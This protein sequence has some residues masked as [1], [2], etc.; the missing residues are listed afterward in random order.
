[1]LS[2][3]LGALPLLHPL[4]RDRRRALADCLFVFG[5]VLARSPA[6]RR[7]E[8]RAQPAAGRTRA[9]RARPGGADRMA[10]GDRRRRLRRADRGP[11]AIR[12][13]CGGSSCRCRRRVSPPRSWA[14]RRSTGRWPVRSSTCCCLPVRRRSRPCSAPSSRRSC[15]AWPAT[16]RAASAI[17]EGLMVLLLKPYLSSAELLPTLV[18]YRAVYYLLAAVGGPRGSGRRRNQAAPLTNR[19]GDGAARPVVGGADAA[20]AGHL[21]LPRR[22]GAALLGRDARRR[23]TAQ[24]AAP[25]GAARRHRDVAL[26]RQ[27]G[28]RGAA[29]VVA[30]T[31]P[32]ARRGV[33]P[34]GDRPQP[35]DRGVAAERRRLR[36]G[37]LSAHSC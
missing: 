20:R 25:A 29:A 6:A 1:M 31:R 23:G 9:A 12:F 19:A 14:C 30:G 28:G 27:P 26:P 10:V 4:G 22:T 37:G 35:R 17:F 18:V 2:G 15:S 21:H 24:T 32:A 33:L 7:L 5:H 8:P 3:R 13:V 16:F 11:P 36:R 34:D